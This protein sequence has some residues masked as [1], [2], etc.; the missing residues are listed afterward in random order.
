MRRKELQFAL[1]W[2]R[3]AEPV[4][5]AVSDFLRWLGN[6]VGR[7]VLPKVALSYDEI[8]P[9]F[10]RGAVDIGWLP[11]LSFLQLRSRKLVRSLLV[12]QRH[13]ARA[14][15]AILAV[16]SGSRH[17][18]LD[19]MRGARAAWVDPHSATGYALARMDLAAHGIDPGSTFGEERF[20]GSHDAAARAVLEGRSDVLGTFAEYE[21]DRIARA[22]FTSQGSA[23]DW[24]VVLRGRECPSDVLATHASLDDAT[25]DA[26]KSALTSALASPRE[27]ALLRDVLH[28][29]AFGEADDAR[30]AALADAV[31]TARRTGVLPHL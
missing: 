17:Y 11:P 31:E 7:P 4:G 15:H 10:E 20:F 18:S 23:S 30:Y 29:E 19:R 3:N 21:G 25:R 8:V 14:F 22:G 27:G 9:L 5:A 26:L 12:N 13:G 6:A 16:R 28:V 2:Q 24:R 1:T